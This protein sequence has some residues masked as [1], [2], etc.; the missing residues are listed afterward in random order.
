MTEQ[1][2]RRMLI[3]IE[4]DGHG[5]V[6][7]QRQT[8]GPSVQQY[9]EEAAQKLCNRPTP[10]QGSGRTD[11]GVHATAQAAHLD[12][13]A[14]L[15]ER[16]VMMGLNAWLQS[17]KVSVLSAQRVDDG[18]NARFDAVERRYLY[19]ILDRPT[20]SALDRHR[21]WHHTQKLDVDAMQKAADHLMGR[22]DFSSF[23]AAGCQAD[24]PVRTLDRLEVSRMGDEVHLKA[25][26]RSF[27]YH[28]IRNFAGTLSHVGRGRWQPDDVK[29]ILE[30]CDRTRA[31]P[32]A[33]P[34]GLYLTAIIYQEPV[35]G[36]ERFPA[37][38][39][40]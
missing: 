19:R 10:L 35:G 5:L 37:G 38:L 1:A 33:P 16:A 23:R 13:P 20:S 12:V 6:G 9:L 15:D 25:S 27:L 39:S 3:R 14:H 2:L 40:Q 30:A 17:E 18:F 8:N 11:A 4:Y 32:T 22:H 7:W 31:G 28:Q 26:A 34:Q 21:V 29:D 36:T 24:S